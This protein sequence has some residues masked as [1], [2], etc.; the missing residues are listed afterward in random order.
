MMIT[1][2]LTVLN[3]QVAA[4]ADST[5]IF[6]SPLAAPAPSCGLCHIVIVN[7]VALYVAYYSVPI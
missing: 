7:A 1:I 5:G 3:G 6:V 2:M 4:Q